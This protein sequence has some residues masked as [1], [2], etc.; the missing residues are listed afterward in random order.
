MGPGEESSSERGG[1]K[2]SLYFEDLLILM[3]IAVLFVLGVFFRDRLWAQAVLLVVLANRPGFY[4]LPDEKCVR[5]H[6]RV[7]FHISSE[8]TW[9]AFS[10]MW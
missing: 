3:A 2:K 9:P 5:N 8:R 6:W 1:S 7:R 4:V 10:S